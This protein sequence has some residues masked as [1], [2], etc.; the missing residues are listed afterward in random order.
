MS[1]VWDDEIEE[2]WNY[3][4]ISYH[5]YLFWKPG[6]WEE[7]TSS[8]PC[9][10]G[11]MLVQIPALLFNNHLLWTGHFISLSLN[12]SLC[13]RGVMVPAFLQPRENQ[14]GRPR[15]LCCVGCSTPEGLFPL[16]VVFQLN[17]YS[18][19]EGHF[20]KSH[21][22]SWGLCCVIWKVVIIMP[23][24]QGLPWVWNETT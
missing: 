23:G 21:L 11:W 1:I 9:E 16:V 17:K 18:L 7:A 20:L 4:N 6:V 2:D 19:N 15:A 22:N 14:D 8:P 3:T 24:C 5:S 13:K 12:F 10:A